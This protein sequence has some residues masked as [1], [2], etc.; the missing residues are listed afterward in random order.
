MAHAVF[1]CD[2]GSPS[3][4]TSSKTNDHQERKP[5]EISTSSSPR[6]DGCGE[7]V[8]A[9]GGIKD[10]AT[11]P[12]LDHRCCMR[13]SPVLARYVRRHRSDLA[14]H[15]PDQLDFRHISI[16]SFSVFVIRI[17]IMQLYQA[18]RTKYGRLD[19]G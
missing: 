16:A 3:K 4:S 13:T 10:G 15:R 19:A 7:A 1:D 6:V 5:A 17:I 18:Y 12:N 2:L 9:H 11:G 14:A 8:N